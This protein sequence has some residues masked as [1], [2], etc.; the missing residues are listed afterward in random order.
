[1]GQ[2]PP[3]NALRAFE[4]AGRHLNF[5]LAA[6]DIGVTQGAV[7]QHIR[8][9]EARLGVQLF[10]RLA[11]GVALTHEGRRYLVPVRQAF[12]LIAEATEALAPRRQMLKL[13]VTP[14]FA[15][16]WLVPRLGEFSATYPEIDVR[17]DAA[18][19][20]ANFQS[21]GI[22]IAVRQGTPPFGPGLVAVPLVQEA[23]FAVCSPALKMRLNSP[24]DLAGLALL[25]D[26]HGLWPLY[27]EKLFAGRDRSATNKRRMNFSQTSLAIDAA[28]AGQGVALASELFVGDDIR[29]GRLCRPF[30]VEITSR[31]G[32]YLVTPIVERKPAL[33]AKMRDWLIAQSTAT[34]PGAAKPIVGPMDG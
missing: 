10:E 9:L 32:F 23:Y 4:A 13:S 25:H 6:E 31:F 3:L 22:D 14:T 16:K 11:R 17:V 26:A 5:R 12:E 7:A 1:M 30:S 28:I 2:L 20:L 27:L 19:G 8:A 29:A 18:Q 21:D 33:V 24:D 15:S 34:G